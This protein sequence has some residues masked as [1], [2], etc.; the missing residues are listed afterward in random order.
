M[1]NYN[2]I[3]DIENFIEN[4]VNPT[5]YSDNCPYQLPFYQTRETLINIEDYKK[6]LD[7]S[8]SRFHHS[9]TY[10]RYKGYLIDLGLNRCHFHSNITNEMATIEMHHNMITIYDIAII[11]TEHVI[12]TRGYISSFDLVQL[13]KEEHKANNIQLVMLSLTPHQ[14]YHDNPDFFIH[15]HMCF[16][17]WPHFLTKYNK[18]ITL[19]IAFKILFYLKKAVENNNSQDN[20]LLDIRDK[21]LNWSGL[22]NHMYLEGGFDYNGGIT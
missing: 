15:P 18:G 1:P 12:N 5:I 21:I 2:K 14:L 19:D 16:G 10:K 6:F 8:I 13:L 20:Q 4:G 9:R 22:N 17:N 3:P 7:N 11:I